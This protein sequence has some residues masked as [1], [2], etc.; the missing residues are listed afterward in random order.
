MMRMK[1]K[2]KCKFNPRLGCTH[3]E[4]LSQQKKWQEGQRRKEGRLGAKERKI[5]GQ[6]WKC[7]ISD[8]CFIY[9]DIWNISGYVNIE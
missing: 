7:K 4:T 5:K 9:V 8:K 1:A 3:T 6:E 2:P